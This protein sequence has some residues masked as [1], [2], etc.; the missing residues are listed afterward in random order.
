[1]G[2]LARG[3]LGG[4][5]GGFKAYGEVV[6]DKMEAKREK[7]KQDALLKRQKDLA[8]FEQG[9]SRD[10]IKDERKYQEKQTKEARGYEEKQEEE[11]F[12]R[13][14]E[15]LGIKTEAQKELARE[16]GKI[17]K[18]L[19]LLKASNKAPSD[20]DLERIEEKAE[21]NVRAF[22]GTMGGEQYDPENDR[23]YIIPE[24]LPDKEIENIVKSI[25]SAGFNVYAKKVDGEVQFDLGGFAPDK[26]G[27]ETEGKKK[28][29]PMGDDWLERA[30]AAEEKVQKA[31]EEKRLKKAQE[32]GIEV[33]G[34][35]MSALPEKESGSGTILQG[36]NPDQEQEQSFVQS[37]K[38]GL[39][40]PRQDEKGWTYVGKVRSGEVWKRPEDGALFIKTPQGLSLLTDEEEKKELAFQ[41]GR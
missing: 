41:Q 27:K 32:T 23:Q 2:D 30:R 33:P 18:E 6:D 3:I 8:K 9:L 7:A 21:N 20:E 26:I 15:F 39:A 38:K 25:E 36:A 34:A 24:D 1:M 11:K 4:A 37:R 5:A 28:K 13:K 14:K 40:A 22:L 16:R 19:T 17:N 29:K 31:N 10:L 12:G 35:K